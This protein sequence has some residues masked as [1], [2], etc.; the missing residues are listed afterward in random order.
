MKY[1]GSIDDRTLQH[2]MPH[3]NRSSLTYIER[4]FTSQHRNMED[5]VHLGERGCFHSVW[6]I[7]HEQYKLS[8]QSLPVD[9]SN[10]LT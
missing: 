4:F 9:R 7:T 2:C 8:I 3:R 1:I 10:I 5:S 6:L